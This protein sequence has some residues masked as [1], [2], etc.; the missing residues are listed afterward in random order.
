MASPDLEKFTSMISK[1]TTGPTVVYE[2]LCE[3]TIKDESKIQ[4]H[5]GLENHFCRSSSINAQFIKVASFVADHFC[6]RLSLHT[7][8]SEKIALRRFKTIR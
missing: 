2:G 3:E 6:F 1:S 8:R 4:V 5:S 7:I